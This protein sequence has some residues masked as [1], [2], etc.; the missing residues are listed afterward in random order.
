MELK[1]TEGL[2]PEVNIW[3]ITFSRGL[4]K[5]LGKNIHDKYLVKWFFDDKFQG[6]YNLSSGMWG[7]FNIKVGI[8]R[9]EFWKDGK[10]QSDYV[11]NLKNKNI[12]IIATFKN[13][14]IGKNLDVNNLLERGHSLEKEFSCNVIFYFRNSEKYNISP[15]QTLKMNDEI[16]FSLILEESFEDLTQSVIEFRKHE[17]YFKQDEIIKVYG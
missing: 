1:L 13:K 7:A 9:F 11:H 2:G 8:W 16:N 5:V 3:N 10:M 15:F 4:V 12:L 17:E 14:T 6:E